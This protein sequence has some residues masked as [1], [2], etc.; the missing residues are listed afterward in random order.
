ML[1]LNIQKLKNLKNLKTIQNK[2][3]GNY[4]KVLR[5]ITSKKIIKGNNFIKDKFI[6]DKFIKAN[7]IK[8]KKIKNQNFY[9]KQK[10]I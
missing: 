2:S 4:M 1:M 6:K 9:K 7:F 3:K 10:K 8:T 5:Q